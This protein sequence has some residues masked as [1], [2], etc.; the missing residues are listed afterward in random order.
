MSVKPF[1]FLVAVLL[2]PALAGCTQ[3][4]E[5]PRR[6]PSFELPVL[7][8][9]T[10]ALSDR[11]GSVLLVNFWASWCSP[12]RKEMPELDALYR[13]YRDQGLTV[14]GISVDPRA[15]QARA[16]ADDLD[17]SYPLLLDSDMRVSGDY[18][19]RAMPSTVVVDAA[20]R[21]RHTQLG[22][23]PGTMEELEAVIRKLLAEAEAGSAEG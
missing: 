19:V 13:Q 11:D 12:C 21:I 7:N 22:F 5:E 17:V 3:D 16:F 8:G 6:A 2:L 10:L 9:G 18:K 1:T 15:E 14:W 20:G 23:E 4:P